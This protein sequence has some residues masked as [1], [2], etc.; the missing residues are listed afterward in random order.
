MRAYIIRRLLLLVPMMLAVS[1]L[2]FAAFRIIPADACVLNLGFG[3][4]PETLA[5]CQEEHGL[6]RPWYEQYW[7]WLNGIPQG[8]LGASMGESDLKVTTELDRRMP[9]TMQLMIMTVLFTTVLGVPLGILSAI[10]P[11]SVYDAVARF[12][13]ILWLSVPAFYLGTLVVIFGSRWFGWTPPQFETGY[14]PFMDDPL[15]N[16]EQFAIPALVLALGSSGLVMR[17]TRS[18]ML[19]VLRNDYIRTAWSKG[20]RERSVVWRHALKNALI[21]VVTVI[22]LE[23]GGLLGGAVLV[24]TIF[25]LNGIGVYMIQS[26]ILRDVFVVQAMAFLFAFV[27]V[28]T[29][30]GVDLVYAWLDPR[31]RYA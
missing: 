2:T 9:I 14:T 1:F 7:D 6:N 13:T 24:E 30:L 10:R 31:I 3:T 23:I 4:T 20:L 26:V 22:G 12:T 27:Y 15:T 29:N 11:G 8:D 17:L 25:G 18:S 19:E 16:L 5:A 28:L 21:P